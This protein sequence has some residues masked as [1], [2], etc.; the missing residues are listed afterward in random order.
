MKN[1]NTADGRQLLQ[2]FIDRY[3]PSPWTTTAKEAMN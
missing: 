3:P 2:N 1:G